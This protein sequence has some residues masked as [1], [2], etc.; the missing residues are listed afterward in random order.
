MNHSQASQ[1][2]PVRSISKKGKKTGLDWTLKLY[3]LPIANF[4]TPIILSRPYPADDIPYSPQR[5]HIT[6]TNVSFYSYT[7]RYCALNSAP[8]EYYLSY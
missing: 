5:H 8:A 6:A 1:S 2:S 4:C 3:L 7:S